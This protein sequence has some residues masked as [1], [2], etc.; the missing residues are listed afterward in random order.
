MSHHP[1]LSAF[2]CG[3]NGFQDDQLISELK[4]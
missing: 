1:Q 2:I 3:K 4:E